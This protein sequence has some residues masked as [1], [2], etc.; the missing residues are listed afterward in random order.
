MTRRYWLPAI[1][2][3]YIASTI[4]RLNRSYSALDLDAI[5]SATNTVLISSTVIILL[6]ARHFGFNDYVPNAR[7]KWLWRSRDEV[8]PCAE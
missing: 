4:T 1:S 7:W 5:A 8:K 3:S 6:P 2:N